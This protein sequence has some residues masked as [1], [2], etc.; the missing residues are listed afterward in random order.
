MNPYHNLHHVVD[1]LQCCY[2]WLHELLPELLG[3]L[4][5]DW[6]M[7]IVLACLCHDLGHSSF[8][9]A[10]LS[11]IGHP[12]CQMFG[13]RSVLEH[14]HSMIL[15]ALLRQ[16]A[17]DPLWGVERERKQRIRERVVECVMATDM[18]THFDFITRF[19]S[20]FLEAET[21]TMLKK[22]LASASASTSK[23][24]T[25]NNSVTLN[26]SNSPLLS[27]RQSLLIAAALVKCSDISNVCRP[28]PIA[29]QWG[30]ALLSEFLHQGDFERSLGLAL[31]PLNDRSTL[32]VAEGQRG[33]LQKVAGPLYLA[34]AEQFPGI[35]PIL[36]QLRLNY[37]EWGKECK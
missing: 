23:P 1:V 28:F 36:T 8:G 7:S 27:D 5:S 19:K 32:N 26:S 30:H 31:G 25:L 16:P 6:V 10:F 13:S 14:Q 3:M 37:D 4:S 34:F 11:N 12:L 35:E 29:K 17:L 2:Y 21:T 9:N 15:S 20:N 18:S 33:F 22:T 24:A